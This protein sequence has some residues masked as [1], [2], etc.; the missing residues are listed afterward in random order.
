MRYPTGSR[1]PI[2][3]KDG[4]TVPGDWILWEEKKWDTVTWALRRLA[5]GIRILRELEHRVDLL[6]LS[7]EKFD[8]K[9]NL[10]AELADA[11]GGVRSNIFDESTPREPPQR[12]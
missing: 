4:R 6:G 2:P 10:I 12:A 5:E 7:L 11:G 9:Q 3:D 1:I 8:P